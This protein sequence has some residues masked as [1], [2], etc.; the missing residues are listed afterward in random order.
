VLKTRSLG[1]LLLT[2]VDIGIRV[3]SQPHV[4][5]LLQ[6]FTESGLA[7]GR[8]QVKSQ[9]ASAENVSLFHYELPARFEP[10]RG[11]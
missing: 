5:V 11:A 1:K 4:Q 10:R 8:D 7:A 3:G 2:R 6:F 9:I